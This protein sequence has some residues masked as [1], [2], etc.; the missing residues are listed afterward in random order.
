MVADAPGGGP[1]DAC[2]RPEKPAGDPSERVPVGFPGPDASPRAMPVAGATRGQINYVLC[3]QRG[4][5]NNLWIFF[6]SL[7][8]LMNILSAINYFDKHS[9]GLR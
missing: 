9:F 6:L 4:G 8:I 3:K 1:A 2:G 5:P 7:T